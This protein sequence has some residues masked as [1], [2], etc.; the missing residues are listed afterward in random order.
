MLKLLSSIL[1]PFNLPDTYIETIDSVVFL[2]G[3]LIRSCIEAEFCF[4][5]HLIDVIDNFGW[6]GVFNTASYAAPYPNVLPDTPLYIEQVSDD[7]A[8]HFRMKNG[9][10]ER[11]D[12]SIDRSN[13]PD[14]KNYVVVYANSLTNKTF[15]SEYGYRMQYLRS[16]VSAF[17]CNNH[18]S[19]YDHESWAL[20]IAGNFIDNLL[21]RQ[22]AVAD[23]TGRYSASEAYANFGNTLYHGA[24]VAF[25][26]R[27]DRIPIAL[28]DSSL[29]VIGV[30]PTDDI[31]QVA[32]E[33]L[34]PKLSLRV[35]W[36]DEILGAKLDSK[37][38][39]YSYLKALNITDVFIKH[40]LVEFS[41]WRKALESNSL[42]DIIAS[43]FLGDTV[44]GPLLHN[45]PNAS[46][47]VMWHT[48]KT[49]VH[50]AQFIHSGD[51]HH[52][53][54]SIIT[55]IRIDNCIASGQ[56]VLNSDVLPLI[57]L[58]GF[59]IREIDDRLVL[60]NCFGAPLGR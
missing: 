48:T 22:T 31:A 33:A 23:S 54:I 35:R 37:S 10:L 46:I 38:F 44:R 2:R 24:K 42:D 4:D 21:R 27:E 25:S 8:I 11:F 14:L 58:N 49:E 50:D 32:I 18:F 16:V 45:R 47:P 1:K 30:E 3:N 57:G 59:T 12:I 6:E 43:I 53:A 28:Y 52:T 26:K 51:V 60:C 39:R 34:S 19:F 5:M 55:D 13:A 36:D 56:L 7:H 29:Q 9:V 15:G 41:D 20:M 17:E 40:L